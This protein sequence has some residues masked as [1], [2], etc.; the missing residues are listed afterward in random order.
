MSLLQDAWVVLPQTATRKDFNLCKREL[1]R[2]RKAPRR[3]KL[4]LL[5]KMAAFISVFLF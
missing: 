1:V 3:K 4:D 2:R 5:F